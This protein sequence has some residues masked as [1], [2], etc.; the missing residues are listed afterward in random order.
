[1]FKEFHKQTD[2]THAGFSIPSNEADW[3]K[4]W[5]TIFFKEY[6]RAPLIPLPK[7][8]PISQ[9][10]S[11]ILT[12]RSSR[13]SYDTEKMISLE[14]ISSILSTSAGL[15][16]NSFSEN[17]FND[18]KR[19]YPSGGARYPLEIYLAAH[20]VKS[21]EPSIYHYN[22]KKHGL[23][24]IFTQKELSACKD[25]TSYPWANTAPLQIIITSCWDRSATKY[26]DLAY[27]LTLIEAGHLG[28]NICLTATSLNIN[29]CPLLGFNNG[30]V[31]EIL[32]IHHDD[33][34][35]SIYLFS[36]GYSK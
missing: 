33:K 8:L 7:P 30:K 34:E 25:I 5:S 22:I 11:D 13:R 9:T 2:A 36:L 10:L 4:D 31:D 23:E 27:R 35:G 6:A 18:S 20:K 16:E 21:L 24:K 15:K 3:P 32:D 28:Q 29:S 17:N 14:D 26:K 19:K 1:M 12:E